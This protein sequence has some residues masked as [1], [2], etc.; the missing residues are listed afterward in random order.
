MVFLSWVWVRRQRRAGVGVPLPLQTPGA[1]GPAGADGFPGV[2]GASP[3]LPGSPGR[4]VAPG[5]PSMVPVQPTDRER[6]SRP[7]A[8]V[9]RTIA[10]GPPANVIFGTPRPHETGALHPYW[11]EAPWPVREKTVLVKQ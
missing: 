10:L 4:V 9:R 1:P 11:H 2:P 3:G 8:A 7:P 6:A 5:P